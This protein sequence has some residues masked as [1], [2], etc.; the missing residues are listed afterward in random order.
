MQD[1]ACRGSPCCPSSRRPPGPGYKARICPT[2]VLRSWD[3]ALSKNICLPSWHLKLLISSKIQEWFRIDYRCVF[4]VGEIAD[5]SQC[6]GVAQA[7]STTQSTGKT[8]RLKLKKV[9]NLFCLLSVSTCQTSSCCLHLQ[10]ALNSQ[11]RQ[12]YQFWCHQLWVWTRG[13]TVPIFKGNLS[14]SPSIKIHRC[15]KFLYMS[16]L[17]MYSKN[18]IAKINRNYA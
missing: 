4:L 11:L 10:S 18:P 14:W 16:I 8:A 13:K 15:S 17:R 12:M 3:H 6:S 1:H 9:M 7:P 5:M 2:P